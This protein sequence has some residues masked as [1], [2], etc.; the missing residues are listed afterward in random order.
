MIPKYFGT[1]LKPSQI[2]ERRRE[3]A[4]FEGRP[5]RQ[6]VIGSDDILNL[7]IAL[8]TS[9]SLEDFLGKV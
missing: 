6:T 9:T 4:L 5:D 1:P 7:K 2:V 8:E 3:L